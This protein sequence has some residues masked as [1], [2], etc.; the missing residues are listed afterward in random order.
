MEEEEEENG[1]NEGQLGER[2]ERSRSNWEHVKQERL[3]AAGAMKGGRRVQKKR[4]ERE[5]QKTGKMF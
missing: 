1:G 4:R 2:V 3:T 5:K